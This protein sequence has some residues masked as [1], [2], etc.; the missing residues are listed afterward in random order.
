MKQRSF[1][2]AFRLALYAFLS[3]WRR[4][5]LQLAAL[6]VGLAA[7]T[8]LWSGVQALNGEAKRSYAKA[9]ALAGG[10]GAASL[11]APGGGRFP[12]A[13][14][15]E[16]RRE[17]LRVSPVLEGRVRLTEGRTLRVLGVE[18]LSAPRSALTADFASEDSAVGGAAFIRPPWR[19][20]LAP[21]TMNQL[22]AREGEPLTLAEGRRTPPIHAAPDAPPGVL[23]V[24]IGAAEELLGAR[25]EIDRLLLDPAAPRPDRSIAEILAGRLVLAEAPENDFDR[26]TASFHLNLTAFGL[27]SFV[28]GLFIAH[29]AIGL[30]FEQ[31]RATL[32]TVRALGV[33]ARTAAAA[34]LVETLVFALVAG[35]A[36]L[37]LGYAIAGALAPGVAATLSALYGAPS[38]G[39]LRFDPLWALSGLAMSLFG[40][41]AAAGQSLWKSL[42]MPL[43]STVGA[44]AWRGAQ[45]R[46]LARQGAAG[47][48]L[49]AIAAILAAGAAKGLLLGFALLGALLLGA[50]LTLPALLSLVLEAGRAAARRPLALWFW[51]DARREISGLSLALGALLL[52]LSAN[53]GVGA[54]V[55]GFRAAFET[56]LDARLGA[57]IY[58]HASDEERAAEIRAWAE[59]REEVRAV[60]PGWEARVRLEGWPVELRGF[61]DHAT[62]RESWP[63]IEAAPRAWDRVFAGEALLISE[64]LARRLELGLG[65]RLAL[66]TEVGPW[67]PEIAGVYADYGNPR[68]Q[69]VLSGPALEARMAGLDRRGFAVRAA[70][71]DA[72]AL[73]SALRARFELSEREAVDQQSLKTFARRA[74]EQ[75]FAVTGALN[76]LTFLVAGVALLASL[77]SLSGRRI[78]QLAPLWAL[79]LPRKR[80]A[81]LDLAQTLAL[82]LITA[83]FAIPVGMA[84]AWALVAVVNVEAFGWRLPLTAFPWEWLR[85]T[86]L[87]LLAALAA[88]APGYWRLRR[89]PPERLLRLLSEER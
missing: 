26:L 69:I 87:A 81:A 52:A 4:H 86:A 3:H 43:L 31:R 50:A 12:T 71:E 33:S 8:A 44:E 19:G 27:L 41:L 10:D 74:F 77:A 84:L 54:M 57:E 80:V 64:Q 83:A 5:P 25:G 40:A 38:S 49:L 73:L 2:R 47:L 29:A 6:L 28:V 75:T 37:A 15:A 32:R 58:V 13:L 42:R 89:T 21:E 66:P 46:W 65:D 17:G 35:A 61:V 23:L 45:F 34:L 9:S 68:G 51:S 22:G 24:D 36:G 56:W 39:A 88:A 59:D 85:L 18:P 72:E 1:A 30:A 79:G 53:I 14:F 62:Y 70:P 78:A 60:L 76:A 82:A 11:T 67:E 48:A 16:L 55:G 7:A 63:M 20:L